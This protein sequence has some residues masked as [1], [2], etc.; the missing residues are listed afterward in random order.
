MRQ[1]LWGVKHSVGSYRRDGVE[2]GEGEQNGRRKVKEQGLPW[3]ELSR[4]TKEGV[5][6]ERTRR[7][8]RHHSMVTATKASGEGDT[9]A[10]FCFEK[11]SHTPGA[12]AHM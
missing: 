10:S 8:E 11:V 2:H 12:P 5:Y 4:R 7:T 9:K 1:P 3:N 6:G